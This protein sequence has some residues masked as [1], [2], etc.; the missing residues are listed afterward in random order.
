MKLFCTRAKELLATIP[1][2]KPDAP[3]AQPDAIALLFTKVPEL[4]IEMPIDVAPARP[5]IRVL[6]SM[7]AQA[8]SSQRTPVETGGNPEPEPR[9]ERLPRIV[10]RLEIPVAASRAQ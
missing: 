4:R 1:A 7:R 2:P 3:F 5:L 8:P 10:Q 9:I 6:N